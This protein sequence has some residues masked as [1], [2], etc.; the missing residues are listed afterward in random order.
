MYSHHHSDFT[1]LNPILEDAKFPIPRAEALLGFA[2]QHDVFSTLD[3]TRGYWQANISEESK[4]LT[5]FATEFG[6]FEW[7][8]VP[9]GIHKSGPYFQDLL[10]HTVLAEHIDQS[11][12]IYIDDVLVAS[13]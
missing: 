13:K 5:A 9:M 11:A 12:V 8:R 6:T 1:K 2:T 3:L 7:N 4:P 10:Q